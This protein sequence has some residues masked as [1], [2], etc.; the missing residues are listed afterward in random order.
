M[1]T[2]THQHLW[3]TQESSPFAPGPCPNYGTTPVRS[4]GRGGHWYF[5]EPGPT[6]TSDLEGSSDPQ[7]FHTHDPRAPDST[8]RSES[9]LSHTT[10][11]P[12]TDT[13][14]SF[15]HFERSAEPGEY[16]S[17]WVVLRPL[18]GPVCGG[19]GQW[20]GCGDFQPRVSLPV[21]GTCEC[22]WTSC[23]RVRVRE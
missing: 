4:R 6:K 16:T 14:P 21:A 11:G 12:S 18:Q 20:N 15:P 7:P 5:P 23:V 10:G 1:F 3:P 9:V 8:W 22:Q 13:S 17:S 19:R 2:K